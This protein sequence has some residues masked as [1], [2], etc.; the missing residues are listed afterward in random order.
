M[1][2]TMLFPLDTS[3]PTAFIVLPP[4]NFLA[5]G[6]HPTTSGNSGLPGC[7]SLLPIHFA[8]LHEREVQPAKTERCNKRDGWLFLPPDANVQSP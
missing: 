5:I 2:A 3:I 4:V 1:I 8:W 7:V 6:T